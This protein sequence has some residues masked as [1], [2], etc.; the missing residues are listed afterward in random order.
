MSI[1]KT[2]KTCQVN[3]DWEAGYI[4]QYKNK[5]RYRLRRIQATTANNY[6]FKRLIINTLVDKKDIYC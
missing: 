4:V 5:S 1:L 3:T 2:Y 6:C